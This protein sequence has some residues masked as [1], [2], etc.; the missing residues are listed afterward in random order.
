MNLL[1][2]LV[3]SLS[4]F[5]KVENP[6][7][8]DFLCVAGILLSIVVKPGAERPGFL[9]LL[10]AATLTEVARAEVDTVFPVTLHGMYCDPKP[11]TA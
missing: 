6:S 2:F 5:P 10:D 1:R 11:D 7:D 4:H 9:L 8:E 3:S